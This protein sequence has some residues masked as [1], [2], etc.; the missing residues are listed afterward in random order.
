[1]TSSLLC[2]HYPIAG[3]I[4]N[5]QNMLPHYLLKSNDHFHTILYKVLNPVEII[6]PT[7]SVNIIGMGGG[8]LVGRKLK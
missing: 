6:E 2:A 7:R 1:M 4:V 5:Q 3:P 8:G